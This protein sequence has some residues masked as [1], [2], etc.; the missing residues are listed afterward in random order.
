MS[1]Q[2]NTIECPTHGTTSE[3][4]VCQH[5]V[6][7]ARKLGFNVGYGLDDPDEYYPDA[8]CDECEKMLEAEGEWT[9][10]AEAFADIKIVCA[11]CYLDIRERNWKQDDEAWNAFETEACQ[12]LDSRQKKFRKDFKIGDHDRWGRDEETGLLVFSNNG[13]PKVEAEF[14]FAG[15]FSLRSD[16]WMWAWANPG[17]EEKVRIASRKLR[18]LGDEKGFLALSAHLVEATENDAGHF[19]AIMAKELNA[20][21]TYRTFEND[22][23]TYMIITKAWWVKKRK[24]FGLMRG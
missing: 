8:W 20:L 9:E 12:W 21:G 4:W 22:L 7:G 11:G 2:K 14:H 16:T 1:N 24:L 13:E 6:G 5:L 23:Y 3:T 17:F 18:E 19:V 15:S 10:K